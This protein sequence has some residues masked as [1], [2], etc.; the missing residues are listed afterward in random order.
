[1]SPR[2]DKPNKSKHNTQPEK[3]KRVKKTKNQ[4]ALSEST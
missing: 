1:M 3:A 4:P 2:S